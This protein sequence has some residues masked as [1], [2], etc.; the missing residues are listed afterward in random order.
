VIGSK[1]KQQLKPLLTCGK[2]RDGSASAQRRR[3]MD[4]RA[5]RSHGQPKIARATQE[6][7]RNLS[8]VGEHIGSLIDAFPVAQRAGNEDLVSMLH[9]YSQALRPWAAKASAKMIAEVN[10]RD[11]DTWRALAK[12]LSQGV[13]AEIRS[14]P[15]GQVMATLMA[16]QTELIASLP[17]EAAQRP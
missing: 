13:A 2:S 14:T 6:F 11:I 15:V 4:A 8:K 3:A 12:S 17:I 5:K 9:A 1:G 16:E 7:E 10:E